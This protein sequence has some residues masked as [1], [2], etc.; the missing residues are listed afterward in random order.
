MLTRRQLCKI[1]ASVGLGSVFALDAFGKAAPSLRAQEPPSGSDYSRDTASSLMTV[2]A[3]EDLWDDLDCEELVAQYTTLGGI[4]VQGYMA[5]D[6]LAQCPFTR[7]KSHTLLVGRESYYC[8]DCDACGT[9]M[10]FYATMEGVS[11]GQAAR[12]LRQLLDAGTLQGR[13]ARHEALWAIMAD[14]AQLYHH[15]LTETPE[16]KPGRRWLEQEGITPATSKRFSLGFAPDIPN[17]LS[18]HLVSRGYSAEQ[19]DAA[20]L[21]LLWPTRVTPTDRHQSEI[22]IPVRGQHGHIWGILFRHLEEDGEPSFRFDLDRMRHLSRN[23]FR[24]LIFP[25]PT[26]PQDL[27]RDDCVL[28]AEDPVDVVLLAQEGITNTVWTG[29]AST[30]DYEMAFRLRTVSGLASR[31]ICPFK[32]KEV[33][34]MLFEELLEKMN[35]RLDHVDLLLLPKGHS[36]RDILRSKGL[37]VLRERLAHPVAIM[38]T[39]GI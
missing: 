10:E 38:D 8:E 3:W 1:A 4:E 25:I 13:R 9:T 21:A 19:I 5:G 26:W 15:T 11:Y 23:R 17:Y 18:G 29:R 20:G 7:T 32:A 34:G 37:A 2:E 36:V 14:A 6:R 35:E 30:D 28:L 22:T 12:R 31:F 16:G 33:G 27:H 39:L 24:R